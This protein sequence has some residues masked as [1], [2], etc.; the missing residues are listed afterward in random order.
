MDA[1][2]GRGA[3]D[4][5]NGKMDADQTG[6]GGVLQGGTRGDQSGASESIPR[7]TI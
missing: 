1:M 3:V 6:G 5:R 2:K 4:S 7:W